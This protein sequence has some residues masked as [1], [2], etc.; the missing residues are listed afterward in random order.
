MPACT[1]TA[2][3]TVKAPSLFSPL[4]DSMT[5]KDSVMPAPLSLNHW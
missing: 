4:P 3:H 1:E 5:D 2:E